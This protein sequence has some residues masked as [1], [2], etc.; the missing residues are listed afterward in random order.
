MENTLMPR[1]IVTISNTGNEKKLKEIFDMSGVPVS[2]SCPAQGTAPS[3]IMDIFGLSGRSK[4]ITAGL[5][6]KSRVKEIFSSLSSGLAFTEKGKG[7]AFTIPLT[8]LQ[9]H[10]LTT[11]EKEKQIIPEGDEI[12]VSEKTYS[13]IF[14]SC[15]IGYSEDVFEVA[16]KAGATGGTIIKGMREISEDFCENLGLPRLEEQDLILIVTPKEIKKDI[17]TVIIN[18]CGI[19]TEAH[20][21]VMSFPIE[22]VFGLR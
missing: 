5:T 12:K 6:V 19:S 18:E 14:A 13:A 17:M 15:T 3:A 1:I 21:T 20:T 4:I 22:D 2:F 7:I 10:V 9:S 8:A 11:L 16:R